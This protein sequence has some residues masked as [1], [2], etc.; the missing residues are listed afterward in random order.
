[1]IV[2]RDLQVRLQERYRRLFNAHYRAFPQELDYFRAFINSHPALSTIMRNVVAAE[3]SFD[4][5]AWAE[6]GIAWNK[7]TLP[8]TERQRVCFLWYLINAWADESRIWHND[9]HE[10]SV[11]ESNLPALIRI[12]IPQFIEPVVDYIQEHLGT[13]SQMLHLLAR[14]AKSVEWFEQQALYDA[15][16][17]DTAKGEEQYDT[18]MR[19]FLFREGID[20]PFTQ[21]RSPA[22]LADVAS[23]LDTSD[24]LVCEVKLYDGGKYGVPYTAQGIQQAYRYARDHGVSIAYCLIFNLSDQRVHWPTDGDPNV[25]PPYLDVAGIRVY[26]ITVAAKPRPSASK[27]RSPETITVARE[28]LVKGSAAGPEAM[29]TVEQ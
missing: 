12:L 3:A 9:A 8:P 2:N 1:V 27:E 25:W 19:S 17:A 26:I 20:M 16:R 5:G 29:E 15:Y 23:G 22:G 24:P 28:Q 13:T 18:H 4:A 21:L 14:Y 11:T 6:A 7:L 10:I